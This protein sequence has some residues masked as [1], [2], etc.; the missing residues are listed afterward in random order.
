MFLLNDFNIVCCAIAT[1]SAAVGYNF[2]MGRRQSRDKDVAHNRRSY[3]RRRSSVSSWFS[4]AS[5]AVESDVSDT[6]S[7]STESS[8]SEQVSDVTEPGS[9]KRKTRDENADY[10]SVGSNSS[11][12]LVTGP[13]RKR[14]RSASP[15]IDHASI[16]IED[17]AATNPAE[18]YASAI[19]PYMKS[20]VND[21]NILRE[22]EAMMLTPQAVNTESP[23]PIL[24]ALTANSI[25]CEEIEASVSISEPMVISPA[26]PL[27]PP[28]TPPPSS[29]PVKFRAFH[30]TL[31]AKAGAFGSSIAIQGC[32][33]SSTS[34]AFS[35]FA[36]TSSGFGGAFG[37]SNLHS[38]RPAWSSNPLDGVSRSEDVFGSDSTLP[39]PSSDVSHAE[40]EE[41]PLAAQSRTKSKQSVTTG[42]E[43]EDVISEIKGIKLFIKRG[44]NEFSSGIIG[45]M[46]LLSHRTTKDERI[47][48]RREPIW[49]VSMSVRL[50]P[51]VRCMYD[52]EQ[53]ALR[54]ILKEAITSDQAG[55]VSDGSQPTETVVYALKRGRVPKADFAAFA[56]KIVE[57]PRLVA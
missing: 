42:E 51:V 10:Q 22:D 19:A 21:S 53:S 38:Q 33:P 43:D 40:V 15:E 46:K 45:N 5:T 48:F 26:A 11:S 28:P 12:G 9:L 52:E 57:N 50:R 32:K 44:D 8:Q 6:S 16:K 34:S 1:V 36:G 25:K 37:S 30:A 55:I 29:T 27:S 18:Q 47:V 49:K 56:K 4:S 31:G 23:V 24:P 54:I 41:D 2:T 3:Q 35:A 7:E 39:R 13:P 14:S 17:P 20:E